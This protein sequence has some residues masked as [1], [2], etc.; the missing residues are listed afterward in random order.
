M[1]WLKKTYR[2]WRVYHRVRGRERLAFS[3]TEEEQARAFCDTLNAARRQARTPE[4]VAH[5]LEST[6]AEVHAHTQTM[7]VLVAEYLAG[8]AAAAKTSTL[9]GYRLHLERLCTAFDEPGWRGLTKGRLQ[10]WLARQPNAN[11]MA[12]SL[13]AFGL[14]LHGER[15]WPENALIRLKARRAQSRQEMLSDDEIAAIAEALTG[16]ELL[17]PFYAGIYAGLRADEICHLR[18]ENVDRRERTLTVAPIAGWSPKNWQ[19]RLL[20]CHPKLLAEIREGDRGWAFVRMDG[21]AWNRYKLLAAMKRRGRCTLHILRHTYVSRL[22]LLG[23]PDSVARDLAGHSSTTVTSGY[24]HTMPAA[25]R[26]A[27]ERL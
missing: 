20:P 18:L 22:M 2:V 17:G 21:G 26:E 14:Y 11:G 10:A 16:T 13:K 1:A 19:R 23:A 12:R 9:A 15:I 27:I 8:K 5:L 24:A 25:L 7:R 4:D 6:A 3:S